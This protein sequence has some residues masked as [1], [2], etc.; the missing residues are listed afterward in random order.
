MELIMK[1]LD[2]ALDYIERGWNPVPVHYRAKHPLTGEGWQHIV[3]DQASAPDYFNGAPMNIGV[4]LGTASNGLTDIDLD[5]TEAIRIAPYVLPATRAI[6]GR[7]SKRASHRLYYTDLANRIDNAV[8]AFNDPNKGVEDG[9]LLELRIGGGGKGAQTVFPGSVH[10]EGEPITWEET[11]D[12]AS[13]DGDDLRR[14]V[15]ALAAYCLLARYWPPQHSGHHDTA[16]VVGGFLARAGRRPEDVRIIVEAI[17]RANGSDRWEELRRT[18]ED[19]AKA[20][21]RGE[22]AFGFPE[23]AKAFGDD[24][25]KEVA[26]WL[27]YQGEK[28]GNQDSSQDSEPAAPLPGFKSSAEFVAGFVPPDYILDGVLQQGF[29]Y[30]LTGMTGAG[31]TAITLRLSASTALGETFAGRETKKMRVLYL[32]AENPD[33]VRMRWIALAQHMGFD[34]NSIDVYFI[35]GCFK[36]ST[37]AFHL[38]AEA[39]KRG[40][41]F[42]LVVIDTSP[43]FFEGD[44]ENN[45]NQ[46]GTHAR[47]LRGLITTIRGRPCVIANC[48]PTKNATAENLLPAGGGSFLNEVDGNLTAAKND[49]T[50]D[51]HWLGK[52]RGVEFAPMHFLIKIVTH[53]DLKDSRGRLIP[54]VICEWI[55]DQRKEEIAAQKNR[56]EDAVLAL[57][58]ANPAIS[59]AQIATEMGWKLYSGQPY[60]V[61]AQRIVEELSRAKLIK[62]TRR[63]RHRVTPEG[64][65]VLNGEE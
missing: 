7:V 5:C 20:H 3:I 64:K 56:D 2:I 19:A 15:R 22:R 21:Q 39:E 23:L 26:K 4:Q 57:I 29:L 60:K 51:L 11:G 52:Y 46:M 44:D 1:P 61:K 62:E 33:D 24:V 55:S 58:D 42:G 16:L 37:A 10:K 50:I 35:E 28:D 53:Q 47:M 27:D 12:P 59:L 14:R 13:V 54:T 8:L 41:E 9:R 18:A 49:L 40:G 30:S 32:A 48:H 31:K 45:R 36:I 38:K 63:G 25:A 6:F 17:A 34:I 43:A 65:R